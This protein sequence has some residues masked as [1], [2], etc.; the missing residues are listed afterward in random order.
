MGGVKEVSEI[1]GA[2]TTGDNGR[3]RLGLTLGVDGHVVL[4]NG[5]DGGSDTIICKGGRVRV[6]DLF[7]VFEERDDGVVLDTCY[8]G[9]TEVELLGI[10]IVLI[11]DGPCACQC[12]DDR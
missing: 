7:S 1:G 3:A 4:P 9:V 8:G 5:E 10:R 2:Q 6:H 12:E 11:G